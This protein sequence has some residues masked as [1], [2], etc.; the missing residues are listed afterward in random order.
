M[1]GALIL[2]V[3]V[4]LG[5]A[6]SGQAGDMLTD[7]EI[8]A[9]VGATDAERAKTF[10]QD[11]LGLRLVG[12]EPGHALVFRSGATMLRVSLVPE[13]P[14]A[15]YTVLGWR[16]EDIEK[17]VDGLVAKGVVFERFPGFNQDQSGVWTTPDGARIAWFRDPDGNMLS[18]TQFPGD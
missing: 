17:A 7:T 3:S 14:S 1:A 10:Y 8:I 15:R 2:V 4:A 6:E 11:K 5:A 9:F 13:V 18:L 12:E 16:V